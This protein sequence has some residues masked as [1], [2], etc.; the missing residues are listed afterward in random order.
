MK[1]KEKKG[2]KER[3]RKE[4]GKEK[5][6]EEKTREDK[7]GT[8][9]ENGRKGKRGPLTNEGEQGSTPTLTPNGI[10]I[11]IPHSPTSCN[12]SLVSSEMHGTVDEH[13]TGVGIPGRTIHVHRYPQLVFWVTMFPQILNFLCQSVDFI[14]LNAA[15]AV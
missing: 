10:Y 7:G 6:R 8:Q 1:G 12:S 5:E 4:K 9:N 11:P 15:T 3:E 13:L 14:T 2:K